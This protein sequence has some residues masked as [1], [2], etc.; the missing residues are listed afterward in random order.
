MIE[1]DLKEFKIGVEN[2]LQERILSYDCLIPS[3]L[4]L[5]SCFRTYVPLYALR[6]LICLI[7]DHCLSQGWTHQKIAIKSNFWYSEVNFRG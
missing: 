2:E 3:S 5:I 7:T 1:T 4:K 6:P